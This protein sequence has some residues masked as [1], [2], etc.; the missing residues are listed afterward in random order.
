MSRVEPFN[1]PEDWS[2]RPRIFRERKN[3]ARQGSPAGILLSPSIPAPGPKGKR[4]REPWQPLIV[5]PYD[6]YLLFRQEMASGSGKRPENHT[7]TIYPR[8]R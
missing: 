7:Q 6:Q 5:D 4:K 8:L 3:R 1:D 2:D